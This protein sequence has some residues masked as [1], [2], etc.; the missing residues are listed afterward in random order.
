M[1][2]PVL[3]VHLAR[4]L[5]DLRAS[6][7]DL[8]VSELDELTEQLDSIRADLRLQKF[9]RGAASQVLLSS[10]LVHKILTYDMV[11]DGW[12]T[13]NAA[14]SVCRL[15]RDA[16]AAVTA[17]TRLQ[18]TADWQ[19]SQW[20]SLSQQASGAVVGVHMAAGVVLRPSGLD[21]D[22]D[23]R[24][25]ARVSISAEVDIFD[26]EGEVNIVDDLHNIHKC[27]GRVTVVCDDR[28][29]HN[30]VYIHNAAYECLAKVSLEHP[31]DLTVLSYCR[32]NDLAGCGEVAMACRNGLL[33]VL[34]RFYAVQ[35]FDC[36]TMEWRSRFGTSYY[37]E[38][39]G[40]AEH[41]LA[42]SEGRITDE[43]FD[44]ANQGGLAVSSDWL[45]VADKG[46]H[47]LQMFALHA[48]LPRLADGAYAEAGA[49]PTKIIGGAGAALGEFTLPVG[50]NFLSLN[51]EDDALLVLELG[52]VSDWT[53]CS[54]AGRP[55]LQV[56]NLEG[57]PLQQFVLDCPSTMPQL[58]RGLRHFLPAFC[59]DEEQG[60]DMTILVYGCYR[61]SSVLT[62]SGALVHN[63][64][65]HTCIAQCR[66]Q[67]PLEI[68]RM[69]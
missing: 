40:R 8:S 37:I 23:T 20:A 39:N 14:A 42:S 27:P 35:V 53:D 49:P 16:V 46:N 59:M 24:V 29:G 3:S 31:P 44:H 48:T 12:A 19:D 21:D 45:V 13:L 56:L 63:I 50:V 9:E 17:A 28:P 51:T 30:E 6:T 52:Y 68:W 64:T 34:D 41:L 2:Q 1:P 22:A 55:R 69:E 15:W 60:A 25:F 36:D 43:V 61:R 57:N 32:V 10:E 7:S 4:C 58:E 26:E 11:S 54:P 38:Q 5:A 66:I 18:L 65:G 47:R 62:S 33:Y 67:V